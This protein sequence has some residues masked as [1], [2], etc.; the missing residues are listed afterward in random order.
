MPSSCCRPLLT[1]TGAHRL[2]YLVPAPGRRR[3]SCCNA[4]QPVGFGP[5][6]AVPITG[7]STSRRVLPPVPD[8]QGKDV[9]A[10]WNAVALAFLG[11]SVWELYVRRRFFAPP[12]RTSQYYDLVTSEVRA[13]SQERYLEQLVAGP[14][15]SPEEHDIIRWGNNAKITIP[16]RFSQSGKH[17]QTYRAATSIECLIGFLYLTD[18]QRLHHVMNYIGLGDGAEG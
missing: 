12:K 4:S 6:P 9:R 7:G 15:L 10:N 1:A 2:L 18:A 8:L 14:F 11:D 13:E 17:A 5:K 16:K 3:V